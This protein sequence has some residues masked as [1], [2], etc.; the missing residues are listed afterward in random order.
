MS[1]HSDQCSNLRVLPGDSRHLGVG[2]HGKTPCV[3]CQ[4]IAPSWKNSL[5]ALP[6]DCRHIGVGRHGKTPVMLCQATVVMEKSPALPGI[7]PV[8]EKLP[9]CFARRLSSY[10]RRQSWKNSLYA[11]PGNC[12]RGKIPVF[13]HAIAGN[14]VSIFAYLWSKLQ[15]LRSFL[16]VLD[17]IYFVLVLLGL[18]WFGWIGVPQLHLNLSPS[19]LVCNISLCLLTT[20][21]NFGLAGKW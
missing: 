11:L 17:L 4:A 8:M 14:H 10:R 7:S 9:A 21:R 12:R 6:G 19:G 2:R 1:F 3:F 15:T 20:W 5:R 18:V 16:S 13:C